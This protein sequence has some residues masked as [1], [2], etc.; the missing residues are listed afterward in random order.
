MDARYELPPGASLRV[1]SSSGDIT[2]VAEERTDIQAPEGAHVEPHPGR[3]EHG[4]GAP[5]EG[6][7]VESA[8]RRRHGK[9][10]LRVLRRLVRGAIHGPRAQ[11][12][13]ERGPYLEIRAG[14][15]GSRDLEVRCPAGTRVSIGT[16]AGDVTLRGEFGDTTVA[17]T[18][19]DVFVDRA[20]ALD[21][22]SVSGDLKV[23]GC[24]GACLLHT[25]SGDIEAEAT[26]P[27]EATTIS[28]QV[29]L[30]RTAGG[31]TV[32]T[33]S[34]SVELVTDG[35]DAVVVRTVSG[36]ITVR[37]ARGRLPS[38]RLRSL[39]GKIDCECPRGTD[40]PLEVTS[41]SGG[42]EVVP[43]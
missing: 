13:R 23:N 41:V 39:S 37:V 19:G 16:I 22:R 3:G 27:A 25:K 24:S 30:H 38:T 40:F 4:E 20:A 14:R 10:A 35:S 21:A 32:R 18:S 2:V 29:R 31:V 5:P 42:I 8:A 11:G 17:T 43:S 12:P 6:T 28:G 33:I 26:G 34:G 15:G 7:R 1:V 9:K 36:R